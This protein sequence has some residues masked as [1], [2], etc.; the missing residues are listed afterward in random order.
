MLLLSTGFEPHIADDHLELYLLR[1]TLTSSQ[2][3]T[4]EEHFLCCQQC[5][6]RREDLQ[7][8]IDL[9]REA[10]RVM[11]RSDSLTALETR[12]HSGVA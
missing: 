2:L 7:N 8:F 11:R 1:H 5:V 12:R 10:V 3:A 9:V 6:S 4:I